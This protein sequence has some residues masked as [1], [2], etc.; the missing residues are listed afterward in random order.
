MGAGAGFLSG[1]GL[2]AAAFFAAFFAPFLPAADLRV[3]DAAAVGL[4]SGLG[5]LSSRAIC[6]LETGL[7]R[8]AG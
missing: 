3:A 1:L 4:G 2:R 7:W 8:G 6:G 5:S